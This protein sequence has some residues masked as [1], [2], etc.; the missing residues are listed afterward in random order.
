MQPEDIIVGR[1]ISFGDNQTSFILSIAEEQLGVVSAYSEDGERM[2]CKD[3]E[4][5]QGVRTGCVEPRKV[6]KIPDLN[7]RNFK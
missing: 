4:S 5:M 6:A 3:F 7:S 2:I 1:V